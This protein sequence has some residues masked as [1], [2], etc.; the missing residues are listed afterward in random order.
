ME[1]DDTGKSSGGSQERTDRLTG[2]ARSAAD[3]RKGGKGRDRRA[4]AFEGAFEASF[5]VLIAGGLG[6][7]IDQSFDTGPVGMLSGVVLGF[8]AMVVRLVRLG[9]ELERIREAEE[10]EKAEAAQA[11]RDAQAN[12][13]TS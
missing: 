1:P 7:W 3:K 6:Y 9:T 12:S 5:S 10:T 13:E 8:A 11:E 4:A 2:I